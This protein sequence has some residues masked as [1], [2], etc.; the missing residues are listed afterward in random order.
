AIVS[1]HQSVGYRIGADVI[2][3]LVK[4][5]KGV[6]GVNCSHADLGYLRQ[7][8]DGCADKVPVLV[9]GPM[10]GLVCLAM[11]G[12]G[13]LTSEGNL[14]PKLCVSAIKAYQAGD[15]AACMGAFGKI[16]R[17][18]GLLY[19][20]GGIRMTKA[21]L[22]KLGL[23]GGYPRAPRKPVKDDKLASVFA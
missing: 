17:A 15:L 9:G 19:E 1:T 21:I 23:P 6:E 18:S 7:I 8:L 11:G 13:Y 20:N 2:S 5:F 4:R 22:N 14:A 12:H 16:V 3:G 10:Q